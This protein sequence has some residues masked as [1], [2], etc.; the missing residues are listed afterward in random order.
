MIGLLAGAAL[1][2]LSAE[3]QDALA[4]CGVDA[5]EVERLLAL[6]WESFDQDHT[7]GGWRAIAG[8]DCYGA[9]AAMIE[10]YLLAS[11]MQPD[12]HDSSSLRWHA[13]Q[14]R[15][16]AGDTE[17]AVALFRGAYDSPEI[18]AESGAGW[19][20]YVDATIAFLESDRAALE[21][22]RERLAGEPRYLEVTD[23]LL[24][25]FGRSYS[26]GFRGACDAAEGGQ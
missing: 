3:R 25:C 23:R 18:V 19:N 24:A 11:T 6:D 10:L 7:P 4:R 13:G 22:A 17:Q 9:A 5:A 8:P 12:A 2:L 14:M 20:A 16:F 15:A 1:S 26:A 21:A